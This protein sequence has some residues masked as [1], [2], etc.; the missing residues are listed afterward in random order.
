[1]TSRRTEHRTT[2]LPHMR[3]RLPDPRVTTAYPPAAMLAYPSRSTTTR[4]GAVCPPACPAHAFPTR[5]CRLGNA[6][7]ADLS[8]LT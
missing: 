3:F 5:A 8:S 4:E 6:C 1:M 7:A 2:I